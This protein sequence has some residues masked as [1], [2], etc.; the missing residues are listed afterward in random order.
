MIR[1]SVLPFRFGRAAGD[2]LSRRMREFYVATA[3]IAFSESSLVEDDRSRVTVPLGLDMIL[4]PALVFKVTA[5]RLATI[6]EIHVLI[7]LVRPHEFVLATHTVIG[8][9][10][11]AI[12]A[13]L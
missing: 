2:L 6:D 4:D 8:G 7:D 10:L 11:R 12:D 3:R 9:I 13:D 1:L 5:E